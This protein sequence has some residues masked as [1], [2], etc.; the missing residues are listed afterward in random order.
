MNNQTVMTGLFGNPVSQSMSPDMHN[1]A[2][3][4]LE[5]NYAYAAFAISKENLPEAVR[6]IRALGFR[7]INVTIPHKV[8]VM[9]YLDEIDDEAREIGAVNTIVNQDGRLIGYNTDGQGFVLSLLEETG[10]QLKGKRVLMI[11]AGGAARAVA[12]SLARHGVQQI[13]VANRS[14]EK[15]EELAAHLK[16]HTD[17]SAIQLNDLNAQQFAE[18]DLLINTTSIGMYPE[19]DVLPIPGEYLH[20]GLLVSDLIYNPLETKLLKEAKMIGAKTHNGMGMF[21]QQGA[22]AFALWTQCDAPID[23]MKETVL[24]KL[25]SK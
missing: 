2:F 1:A 10:V 4:Y 6:G 11:G 21:I 16:K 9:K 18:T 12:V 5:L 13:V 15:A 8:E 24:K 3:K 22:L 20:K 25:K 17:A 7:G 14:Q 19:V 23:V